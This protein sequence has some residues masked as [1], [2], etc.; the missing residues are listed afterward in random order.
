MSRR[1]ARDEQAA[2]FAP[3]SLSDPL[4]KSLGPFQAHSST[5]RAAALTNYPRS[6]SQRQRIIEALASVYP[7]GLTREQ[8]ST[9][10]GI[11]LNSVLPRVVELRDGGWIEES[12]TTR[13]TRQGA[14]ASVLVLT[15]RARQE[16]DGDAA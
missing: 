1:V 4:A 10:L 3:V 8:L 14:S 12:G 16:R 11:V 7:D 9:R 15:E 5:S 6:G 2:L 13:A